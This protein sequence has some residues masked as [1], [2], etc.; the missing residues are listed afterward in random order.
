MD[1]GRRS[2]G[3]FSEGR[4]FGSSALDR[5]PNATANCWKKRNG[6]AWEMIRPTHQ[7]T[8]SRTGKSE[9]W[10]LKRK[11][12]FSPADYMRPKTVVKHYVDSSHPTFLF[13][14]GRVNGLTRVFM[15]HSIMPT[16]T[17]P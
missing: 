4:N 6:N 7:F 3:V 10:K 13:V 17:D 15:P 9:T 12:P 11:P 8:T 16:V 2:T 14:S 1:R 5:G